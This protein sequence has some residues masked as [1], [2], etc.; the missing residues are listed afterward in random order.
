VGGDSSITPAQVKAALAYLQG[1]DISQEDLT[2]YV[3]KAGLDT[4][5]P[6]SST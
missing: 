1:T 5:P 4:R 2:A 3:K 6:L